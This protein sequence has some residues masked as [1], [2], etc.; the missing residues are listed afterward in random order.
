M[1]IKDHDEDDEE[2]AEEAKDGQD[3][4]ASDDADEDE[5]DEVKME[6]KYSQFV[7]ELVPYNPPEMIKERGPSQINDVDLSVKKV[8]EL[9]QISEPDDEDID[10]MILSEKEKAFKE[11]IWANNHKD[12]LS[13]QKKKKEEKQAEKARKILIQNQ[14]QSSSLRSDKSDA[15][16]SPTSIQNLN[17]GVLGPASAVVENLESATQTQK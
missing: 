9:D 15:P 13:K 12:F 14:L 16:G 1:P 10:K 6:K 4:E 2:N 8:L 5:D 17:D 11:V 7:D 3:E